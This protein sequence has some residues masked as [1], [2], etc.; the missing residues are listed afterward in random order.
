MFFDLCAPLVQAG[1]GMVCVCPCVR[2]FIYGRG[3][4][5]EATGARCDDHRSLDLKIVFC[6]QH[7]ETEERRAEEEV[8]RGEEI[9]GKKKG[10]RGKR[11]H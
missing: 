7:R 10:W 4:C 5:T 11:G 3:E 6:S 8:Q 9:G 2:L 1:V